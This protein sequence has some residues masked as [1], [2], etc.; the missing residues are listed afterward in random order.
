MN[1]SEVNKPKRGGGTG[2]FH[3]D[4][5]ELERNSEKVRQYVQ[6]LEKALGHGFRVVGILEIGSFAKDEAVP[7]SDIDTRIY[8]SSETGYA[9][10]TDGSRYKD[11]KIDVHGERYKQ[12]TAEHDK[13]PWI[14]YNWY[15]FNEP[16]SQECTNALQ[17]NVEFGLVDVR[18][19]KYELERLESE[20][21]REHA[22]VLQSNVIYDPDGFLQNKRRELE[23]KIIPA[24]VQYYEKQFLSGIPF[25]VMEHVKPHASDRY[26]AEKNGQIQ[27]VNRAVKYLRNLVAVSTYRVSGEFTYKKTDVLGFYKKY[28][29]EEFDFVQLLYNWKC[30]PVI[31]KDMVEDFLHNP[32]PFF[33]EFQR[34]TTDLNRVGKKVSAVVL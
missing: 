33:E 11:R 22:L 8:V 29:P 1:A 25:D 28:L 26:K 31:R 15:E 30:D 20:P 18:Y 13:K 32:D 7:S 27:W 23:G 19:A 24:M 21:V 4:Q 14:D 12:F 5:S 3:S 10:Q 2:E 16:V 9:R 17:C 34:L 6:L